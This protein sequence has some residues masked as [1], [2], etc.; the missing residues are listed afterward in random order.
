MKRKIYRAAFLCAAMYFLGACG[1]HA[2]NSLS[3]IAP[4]KEYSIQAIEEK[5]IDETVE[6]KVS[7]KTEK[8]SAESELDIDVDTEIKTTLENTDRNNEN[9]L[10]NSKSIWRMDYGAGCEITYE[11]TDTE[12]FFIVSF[13]RTSD[14]FTK[15]NGKSYKENSI[16][17]ENLRLLHLLYC[18]LEGRE[19]EGE[20]ICNE[21][22]AV[23]VLNIFKE[24]YLQNYPIEKI[25]LID[26][27]EAEDE[28]SMAD[29]NT[30]CF[31]DR[32]VSGSSKKSRHAFGLAIDINPLYNPYI[33]KVNGVEK[34]EP[35]NANA[36]ANREEEYPYKIDRDDL[37]YR[38]FT[39]NGFEWGGNWKSVKDYQHF[40]ITLDS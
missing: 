25:K 9:T 23:T 2:P 33:H 36:Y 29:N 12:G 17:V 24:L 4:D 14:V 28:A 3:D 18:D 20:L 38:L 21:Q 27:Y 10:E 1:M 22:I 7:E 19:Q 32:M 8:A 39:E 16:P 31:N 35:A 13:D 40:E 6:Q 30:S 11:D 26:E 5:V 37:A 34:I 15:I